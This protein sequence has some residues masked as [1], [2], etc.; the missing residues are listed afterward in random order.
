MNKPQNILSE[1]IENLGKELQI[2]T[3]CR[4]HWK[5]SYEERNTENA[6]LRA[7]NAAIIKTV[8]DVCD[9]YI[10]R[11]SLDELSTN[12]SFN[13]LYDVVFNP[14]PGAALLKELEGLRAVKRAA[15]KYRLL[16][17]EE[18]NIRIR[19]ELG[20]DISDDYYLFL[21]GD[22]AVKRQELDDALAAAKV[23]E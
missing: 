7:D 20:E 11:Q 22:V 23:G 1:R 5:V 4:D 15:D 6:T 2:M 12:K 19:R 17:E 18:F 9:N 10:R 14:R 13:L 3:T 16:V 8:Q 21:A